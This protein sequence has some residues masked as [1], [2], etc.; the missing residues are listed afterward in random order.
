MKVVVKDWFFNKMQDEACDV[1]LIHTAVRVCVRQ[2]YLQRS[3]LLNCS[4][5]LN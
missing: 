2:R 5:S 3:R 1:H 4:T